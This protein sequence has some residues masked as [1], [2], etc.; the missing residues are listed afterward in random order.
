MKVTLA[1][2]FIVL[3][4]AVDVSGLA[5]IGALMGSLHELR[6]LRMRSS[7]GSLARSPDQSQVRGVKSLYPLKSSDNYYNYY[8]NGYAPNA[9]NG[10]SMG[11]YYGYS[12]GWYPNNGAL[13]YQK[14]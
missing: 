3:L 5:G 7:H 11:G 4:L 6:M 12:N 10:N 1:C 13:R 2:V 9:Y 14:K 8:G